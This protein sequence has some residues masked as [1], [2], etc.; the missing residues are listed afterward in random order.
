[1]YLRYVDDTICIF[2]SKNHIHHFINRL[3]RASVLNF[4]CESMKD[5]QF[6]FLDVSLTLQD[7][8]R[9][10]TSVYI[11]PT[12]KGLY[13]DFNSHTPEQYK[14]SVVNSLVNRAIKTCS[15]EESRN[16]ELRR[17]T[18]VLVNNGYPQIMIDSIIKRRIRATND[19]NHAP[20]DD[21]DADVCFF[22]ELHSASNYDKDGKKLRS[23]A[24]QHITLVSSGKLRIVTYYSS[25]YEHRE[26]NKHRCKLVDR[27]RWRDGFR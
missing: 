12:D 10:S 14:K 9:F 26:N 15:S 23:L 16:A 11:K 4:T 5:G 27:R 13:A 7:D 25:Y 8:G 24:N 3:K 1:M 19:S 22:V 17:L 18:Q 20:N 21:C 2:R 6:H